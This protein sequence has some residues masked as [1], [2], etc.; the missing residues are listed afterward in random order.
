MVA[1]KDKL[2]ILV[3]ENRRDQSKVGAMKASVLKT[4]DTLSL[5][6]NSAPAEDPSQIPE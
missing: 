5:G 4:R 3:A 6:S 1:I 2:E